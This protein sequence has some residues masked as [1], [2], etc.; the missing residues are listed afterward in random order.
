MQKNSMY[1]DYYD[2]E[3]LKYLEQSINLL[4]K[5]LKSSEF[6]FQNVSFKDSK[7]GKKRY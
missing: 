7:D 2:E 1:N 5:I 4:E 3:V 6:I